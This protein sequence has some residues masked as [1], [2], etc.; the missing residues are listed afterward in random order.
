[1]A[2][3]GRP[4]DCTPTVTAR[5]AEA[6]AKGQFVRA[7]CRFAGISSASHYE[8]CKRADAGDGPP[9]SDYASAT[10]AALVAGEQR[11]LT[12]IGDAV[13]NGDWRASLEMLKL[14]HPDDYSRQRLEVTGAEGGPVQVQGLIAEIAEQLKTVSDEAVGIPG[15]L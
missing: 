4:T 13:D 11:H 5:M 1:M 6:L 14:M 2:G 3:E 10:R 8:W 12:N 7:A 15:D 9:F